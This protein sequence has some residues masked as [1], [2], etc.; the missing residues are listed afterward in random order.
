MLFFLKNKL[1]DCGYKVFFYHKSY[2][3]AEYDY[4]YLL[5][6]TKHSKYPDSFNKSFNIKLDP[7]NNT[8]IFYY[9]FYYDETPYHIQKCISNKELENIIEHN[10]LEHYI[11]SIEQEFE[12][13][14]QGIIN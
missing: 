13:Y 2:R 12:R 7:I 11:S 4:D 8:P 14:K 3:N 1:E 5:V 10:F 6:E 9:D